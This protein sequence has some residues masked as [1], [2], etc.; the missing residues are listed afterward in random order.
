M[1][2]EQLLADLARPTFVW[3]LAQGQPDS[4]GA[5]KRAENAAAEIDRIVRG[6]AAEGGR[7][8]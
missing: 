7:S 8:E 4:P 1:N 5:K 2:V 3:R 6:H